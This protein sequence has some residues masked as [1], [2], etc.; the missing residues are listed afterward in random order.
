MIVIK[1]TNQSKPSTDPNKI[2]AS[3]LKDKDTADQNSIPYYVAA[4]F[5]ANKFTQSEFTFVVGNGERYPQAQIR[6]RRAV[7]PGMSDFV[8]RACSLCA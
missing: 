7:G 4:Q 6:S 5:T 3:S 1:L 2:E 8:I